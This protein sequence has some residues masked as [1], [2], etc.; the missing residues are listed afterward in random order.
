[1][2]PKSHQCK[3]LSHF[4]PFDLSKTSV[5]PPKPLQSLPFRPTVSFSLRHLSPHFPATKRLQNAP[6]T[7]YFKRY[8]YR[9][10]FLASTSDG[11]LISL[12]CN[13]SKTSTTL[14]RLCL[15]IKYS[16]FPPTHPINTMSAYM[17]L[18]SLSPQSSPHLTRCKS[19]KYTLLQAVGNYV[20]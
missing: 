20:L 3:N 19:A 7:L 15:H 4:T 11:V 8:I 9:P 5:Q 6:K 16:H 12:N 18:F 13:F 2:T 14:S 17:C 1:M 10:I